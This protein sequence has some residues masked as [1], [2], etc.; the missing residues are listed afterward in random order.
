MDIFQALTEGKRGAVA[1]STEVAEYLLKH[2]DE[3]PAL[4]KALASVNTVLV[5]HAAHALLTVFHRGAGLLE[6]YKAELLTLLLAGEQWELLEQMAKVMPYLGFNEV[7]RQHM[8]DRFW[9]IVHY[10]QSS[11]ARACAVQALVDMA[12]SEKRFERQAQAA[13]TYALE[14]GSKAM[15]ARARNL[16]ARPE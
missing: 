4:I 9:H 13:L 16:L 6:P 14:K 1:R 2:P 11:I 7:D 15:Q 10:G 12:H 8:N 3:L 5:A